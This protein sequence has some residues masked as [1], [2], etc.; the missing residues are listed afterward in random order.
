MLLEPPPTLLCPAGDF[1]PVA[2]DVTAAVWRGVAPVALRDTVTG[3]VPHQATDLRVAVSGGDLR[4]LFDC[5]D[6]D[7]WATKTMRDDRLYEEE[8][9][10]VFLDPVG[11]LECYFEL[12]LNPLNTVLD[13]F[14]RKSPSGLKKETAWDCEGLRT[15]VQRTARG[16]TAE[17]AIPF[18]SLM[19]GCAQMQSWRCN[20]CR[21][22]RPRGHP[23]ELSAWSPTGLALFHVPAR[24]GRLGFV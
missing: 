6:I 13:L 15:A 18:E 5:E 4:V 11:D 14:L 9:V 1:G 20:F 19:P 22:D 21:I 17:L 8:V 16:W 3:G 24:F 2:A 10:E 7:P 12:E 23:R